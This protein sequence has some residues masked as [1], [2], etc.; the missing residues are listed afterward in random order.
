MQTSKDRVYGC[1]L[2][3][4]EDIT[5]ATIVKWIEIHA[6]LAIIRI[7]PDSGSVPEF[8]PGQFITIGLPRDHPPIC[9]TKQYPEHDPRWKKLCR[10][11]YS[12]AS[13]THSREHL[14]LF[15]NIVEDGNLTPKLWEIK[16]QG[17]LWMDGKI[18]GD[19]TLK[20]IPANK[21]LVMIATGTGIA[22]YISMLQS[23]R[24]SRCW[25]LLSLFTA[26]ELKKI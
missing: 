20:Q 21:D 13:S 6:G 8:E 22:P 2:K 9:D 1:N 25:R 11:A 18:K 19:F 12:I 16:E 4:V 26:A 3:D 5:N 23:Y 14:D 17:R 7:A 15:I 24:T 10:R